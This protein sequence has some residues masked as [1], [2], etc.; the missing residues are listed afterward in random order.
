MEHFIHSNSHQYDFNKVINEG[1]DFNQAE[2]QDDDNYI[3][4]MVNPILPV[5]PVVEEQLGLNIKRTFTEDF[6]KEF[7]ANLVW[8]RLH[9]IN[10]G[11]TLQVTQATQKRGWFFIEAGEIF[12][13][14]A[15][16]SLGVNAAVDSIISYLQEYIHNILNYNPSEKRFSYLAD[17]PAT[18]DRI[19]K[20]VQLMPK[21]IFDKIY[22]VL[23]IGELDE[24]R[25]VENTYMGT[26]NTIGISPDGGMFITYLLTRFF[27]WEV[28]IGLTFQVKYTYSNLEKGEKQKKGKEEKALL[29]TIKKPYRI[30]ELTDSIPTFKFLPLQDGRLSIQFKLDYKMEEAET[31]FGFRHLQVFLNEAEN[32][33][34]EQIMYKWST[35]ARDDTYYSQFFP[36][37]LKDAIKLDQVKQI[38][39]GFAMNNKSYAKIIAWLTDYQDGT[40]L[41]T[42]TTL[43][44]VPFIINENGVLV[45][46]TV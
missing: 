16:Y 22:N 3:D 25:F 30:P 43:N 14:K 19:R 29:K 27:N 13:A 37:E 31:A 2:L 32:L 44:N 8:N 17:S 42:I 36:I 21:V 18:L 24:H 45:E 38:K 1:F 33:V 46:K 35:I 28:N 20:F 10:T 11:K 34:R 9:N 40:A 26:R 12:V 6:N 4:S 7:Q 41:Y 5:M 23:F 15:L 39:S